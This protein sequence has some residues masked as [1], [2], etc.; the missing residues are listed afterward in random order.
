MNVKD[1]EP[2]VLTSYHDIG[3]PIKI[4]YRKIYMHE[5]IYFH[6][7]D[8]RTEMVSY[9]VTN[10]DEI[11][12]V[13]KPYIFTIQN[14]PENVREVHDEAIEE[15]QDNIA[16]ELHIKPIINFYTQSLALMEILNNY[17][18]LYKPEKVYFYVDVQSFEIECY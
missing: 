12:I 17:C 15:W 9:I 16:Y 8:I 3:K 1:I 6:I 7:N 14:L 10:K 13:I 5:T 2:P 11:D 18:K 4:Y